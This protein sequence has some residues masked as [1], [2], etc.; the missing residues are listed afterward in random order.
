[1][2]SFRPRTATVTMT[3]RVSKPRGILHSRLEEGGGTGA[4]TP[5]K[6]EKV[7]PLSKE[8]SIL[9]KG[10]RRRHQPWTVAGTGW[11]TKN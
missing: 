2:L 11:T 4:G 8:K 10:W 7:E 1:V 6:G 9:A 5:N 3:G